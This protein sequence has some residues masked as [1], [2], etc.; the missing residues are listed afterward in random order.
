MQL[1]KILSYQEF[2]R[3]LITLCKDK[4]SGTLFLNLKSGQ[5]ARIVL[6]EGEIKWLA[7][8]GFSGEKA[9]AAIRTIDCGRLNFNPSLQIMI[10][11]QNLPSTLKILREIKNKSKHE[12]VQH[13]LPNDNTN[14]SV[15]GNNKLNIIQTNNQ[16]SAC[17]ITEYG[18]LDHTCPV[19][20]YLYSNH[21]KL[22]SPQ[23]SQTQIDQLI[24]S[25]KKNII[26]NHNNNTRAT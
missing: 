15:T 3:S 19:V 24:D 23:L 26:I 18:E 1:G 7:F 2:Y 8:N 9:I 22:L 20:K 25:M 11:N 6:L 10:G 12:D 14:Y 5:C 16:N 21:T 17:K 13:H 4:S